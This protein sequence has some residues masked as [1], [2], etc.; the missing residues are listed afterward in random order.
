MNLDLFSDLIP[1]RASVP[2]ARSRKMD[3][4]SSRTA[5][6]R[7]LAAGTIERHRGVILAALRK[8]G[9]AGKDGIASR[10][11][12]D[13][14]EVCRR[15][16]EMQRAGLV[17]LTGNMVPSARGNPEREWRAVAAA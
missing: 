17:E 11:R 9:P 2:V 7:A 8:Q 1:A 10:C 3:P 4:V 16:S 6:A 15:L 14:V 13:G 5:A 12:L